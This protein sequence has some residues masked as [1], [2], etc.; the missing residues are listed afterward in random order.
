LIDEFP[1]ASFGGRLERIGVEPAPFSS[2]EQ[3]ELIFGDDVGEV[4]LRRDEHLR[5]I[6]EDGSV[7][8]EMVGWAT[9]V[10]A[11]DGPPSTLR[12]GRHGYGCGYGVGTGAARH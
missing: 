11:R 10:G 5:F 2:V 12:S 8:V 4:L 1:V 9:G 3:A 6:D 7:R